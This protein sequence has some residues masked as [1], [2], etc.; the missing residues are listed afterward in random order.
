MSKDI[1]EVGKKY[2]RKRG[3]GYTFKTIYHALF[4]D[5]TGVLLENTCG[6]KAFYTNDEVSD[7]EEYKE[8]RTLTSWVNVYQKDSDGKIFFSSSYWG[9]KEEAIRLCD[10]FD[11]KRID[12]IEIKWTEKV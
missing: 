11:R 2:R 1:F 7:F 10:E 12:T 3:C 9:S 8:P 5:R 6:F 4:V